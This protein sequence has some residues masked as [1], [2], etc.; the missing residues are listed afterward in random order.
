MPAYKNNLAV[1]IVLWLL[2][3]PL[4]I[5]Y[6]AVTRINTCAGCKAGWLI[7]IDTPKGKELMEKYNKKED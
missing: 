1:E 3:I 2:F 6:S 5:I 4:G 7:D